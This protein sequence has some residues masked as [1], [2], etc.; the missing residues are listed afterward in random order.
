MDDSQRVRLY[1]GPYRTPRFRYGQIVADVI[2]GEVRITGLSDGPIPWP[3][4]VR[5][6]SR[7]EP[8]GLVLYQSLVRAV[9]RESNTAVAYWWGVS[10]QTVTKWRKSLRVP[11]TTMGTSRLRAAHAREEPSV[12]GRQTAHEMSRDPR[13][14]AKRRSK[15]AAARRGKPR[16]IHVIEALRKSHL[17]K[18][19]PQMVR[20]K[21]SDAHRRRGTR[22]PWLNPSW[23]PEEDEWLRTLSPAEV[24]RQTGRSLPAIYKRR[25]ILGLTQATD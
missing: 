16:P 24:A 25:R 22:P 6:H 21:M 18:P 17:G 5:V 12:R 11:V 13:R 10:G 9:Q 3:K 19:I 4:G 15:I 8:P 20:R 2:R 14:D 23:T 7:G 1:F